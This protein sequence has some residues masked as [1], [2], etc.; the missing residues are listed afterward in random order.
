MARVTVEDCL[1]NV[2]NPFELVLLGAHR[3]RVLGCGETPTVARDGDKNTVIALR[4]LAA[5][6]ITPTMAMESLITSLQRLPPEPE[7]EPEIDAPEEAIIILAE[8]EDEAEG[9]ETL[10]PDDVEAVIEAEMAGLLR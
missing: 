8:D 3:A 2:T 10:D 1:R 7:L 9:E 5:G 4:E 6:T